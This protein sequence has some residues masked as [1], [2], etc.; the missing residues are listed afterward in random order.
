MLFTY[1]LVVADRMFV[2]GL[3]VSVVTRSM[4][5]RIMATYP[6]AFPDESKREALD[7]RPD[8]ELPQ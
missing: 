5:S 2:F 1:F 3:S 6:D 7:R 4:K 8:L